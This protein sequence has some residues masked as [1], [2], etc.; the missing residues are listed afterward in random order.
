MEV[1][2]IRRLFVPFIVLAL[3]IATIAV[4]GL[5]PGAADAA[6]PLQ[7]SV[8]V[9][10]DPQR[11]A[12]EPGYAIGPWG[13][14]FTAGPWGFSTGQSF[15]WRSLDD[16]NSFDIMKIDES[17]VGLRPCSTAAGPGGGDTDQIAFNA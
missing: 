1:L 8:P 12:T 10:V 9:Q 11:F 3:L 6:T 2:V 14:I 13:A 5:R 4:D 16:A 15:L 17:P 7:F